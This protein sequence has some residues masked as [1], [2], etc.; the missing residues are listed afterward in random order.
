VGLAEITER[1]NKQSGFKVR[2]REREG[3]RC[4]EEIED[5]KWEAN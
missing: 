2:L 5:E 1:K 3:S 4:K